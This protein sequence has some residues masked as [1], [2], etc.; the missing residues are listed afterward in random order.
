MMILLE[1]VKTKDRLLP[2]PALLLLYCRKDSKDTWLPVALDLAT[3]F[4]QLYIYI[5]QNKAM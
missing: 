2:L 4:V 3:Q 1:Q 5:Y